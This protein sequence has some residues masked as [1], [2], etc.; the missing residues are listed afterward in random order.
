MSNGYRL[1]KEIERLKSSLGVTS[2]AHRLSREMKFLKWQILPV[3]VW[4]L[5][6]GAKRMRI[7]GVIF[8]SDLWDRVSQIIAP[9]K[10][11]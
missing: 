4:N 10:G 3:I 9:N 1:S 8:V 5:P 7:D 2:F 6:E 11:Y